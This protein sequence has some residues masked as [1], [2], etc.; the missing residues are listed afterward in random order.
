MYIFYSNNTFFSKKYER[1]FGFPA[2]EAQSNGIFPENHLVISNTTF[3]RL[4]FMNGQ[5]EPLTVV[6]R[7]GKDRVG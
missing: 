7:G 4:P 6:V 3:S 5:K 2:P 1:K